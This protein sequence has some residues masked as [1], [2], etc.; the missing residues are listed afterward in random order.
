M[1][2]C[3][4]EAYLL[5][6]MVINKFFLNF[7]CVRS[8]WIRSVWIRSVWINFV[9]FRF[10]KQRRRKNAVK[11]GHKSRPCT[12]SRKR[13]LI[14]SL[15]RLNHL[16]RQHQVIEHSPNQILRS[17]RLRLGPRPARGPR[18]RAQPRRGLP[19]PGGDGST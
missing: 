13:D 18:S 2:T 3:P 17:P 6:Y 1:I 12:R 9:V 5:S 16:P 10:R 14:H 15:P 4:L 7:V 11:L 8:V 19:G